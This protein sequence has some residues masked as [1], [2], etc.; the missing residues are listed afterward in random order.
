[1]IHDSSSKVMERLCH[2]KAMFLRHMLFLPSL[3]LIMAGLP[4][5]CYGQTEEIPV[6]TI[7]SPSPI[8]KGTKELIQ[9]RVSEGIPGFAVGVIKSGEIVWQEAY[10]WSDIEGKSPLSSE[11]IF[12]I[13]SVAKNLTTHGVLSLVEQYGLDLDRSAGEFLDRDLITELAGKVSEIS[14]RDVLNMTAGFPMGWR[15]CSSKEPKSEM[16]TIM[17]NYGGLIVFPPGEMFHYSNYSLA[18]AQQLI[19]DVSGIPF[20]RFME[21]NLFSPLEMTRSGYMIYDN[22]KY[23]SE[24]VTTY[25]RSG[26]RV[27][28]EC[29]IPSGGAGAFSTLS[30][31]L[32]YTSFHLGNDKLG[33]PKFLDDKMLKSSRQSNNLLADESY[34]LGWWKR[35]IN[36]DTLYISDGQGSGV[37]SLIYL[38]PSLDL[39]IVCLMNSRK[40]EPDWQNRPLTARV[41]T[42]IIESYR[43]GFKKALIDQY[44]DQPTDHYQKEDYLGKWKGFLRYYDDR[45]DSVELD[46]QNDGDIHIKIGNQF[47]TL[48]NFPSFQKPVIRGVFDAAIELDIDYPNDHFI[49]FNL[50]LKGSE[51]H[52]Y[53]MS[54]IRTQSGVFGLPNYLYLQRMQK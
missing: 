42:E 51:A 40:T 11:H 41:A 20:E 45:R 50:F 54:N 6:R 8:H 26:R 30:D 13:A 10:G 22:E 39:G 3:S 43:P 14:I 2:I 32:R 25:S 36:G 48:V 49:N 1:M 12:P 18:I 7:V 37:T 23:S 44:M 53:L 38:V 31:L 35:I 29:G 52:G 19:E 28:D 5:K 17:K 4:S 9:I 16:D 21:K 34:A 33:Q 24:R 46:F 27:L 15:G 47:T